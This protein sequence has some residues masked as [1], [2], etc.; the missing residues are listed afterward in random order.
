LRR[1]R[2]VSANQMCRGIS[3]VEYRRDSNK[4]CQC[5]HQRH[6][7]SEMEMQDASQWLDLFI[8]RIGKSGQES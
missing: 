3:A 4:L 1:F 7:S 6:R 2:R 5:G 8:K